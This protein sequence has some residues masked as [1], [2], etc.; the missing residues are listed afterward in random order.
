VV[1]AAA[2]VGVFLAALSF[3]DKRNEAFLGSD[4]LADRSEDAL[5]QAEAF[6]TSDASICPTS[7]MCAMGTHF[8]SDF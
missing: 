7:G 1:L 6:A 4:F 3:A 8:E 5:S 2:R